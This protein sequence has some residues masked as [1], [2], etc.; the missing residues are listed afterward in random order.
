MYSTENDINKVEKFNELSLLKFTAT[1]DAS[2]LFQF[3]ISFGFKFYEK[4]A[5]FVM[6]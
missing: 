1:Q 3:T 4:K 2:Q 5:K 6:K